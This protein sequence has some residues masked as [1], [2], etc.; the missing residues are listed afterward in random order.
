MK[1]GPQPLPSAA[2]M[3]AVQPSESAGNLL[4]PS[5][6]EKEEVI[7]SKHGLMEREFHHYQPAKGL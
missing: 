4:M 6:G 5:M 3:L 2:P 1:M 7:G